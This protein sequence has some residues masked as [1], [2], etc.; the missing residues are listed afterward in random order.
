MSLYS[1]EL[2]GSLGISEMLFVASIL[3][4]IV[5]NTFQGRLRC[6]AASVEMVGSG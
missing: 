4:V 5:F 3:S 2:S 1:L 6:G